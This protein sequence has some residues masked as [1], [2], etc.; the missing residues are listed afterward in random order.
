MANATLLKESGVW[1]AELVQELVQAATHLAEMLNNTLDI[2]KL[3]EG[4]LEFNTGY[5]HI[6]EPVEVVMS[7]QR[8]AA[9]QKQLKLNT[10]YDPSLPR[11][12]QFDKTRVT[13]VVMNLVGNAIKFAPNGGKVDVDVTWLWKCGR[14]GGQCATCPGWKHD[15]N[16]NRDL[17]QNQN[18]NRQPASVTPKDLGSSSVPGSA[19]ALPVDGS[20]MQLSNPSSVPASNRTRSGSTGGA[21]S[22]EFGQKVRTIK[23]A[24]SHLP[25]PTSP[26]AGQTQAVEPIAVAAEPI[27]NCEPTEPWRRKREPASAGAVEREN[28]EY[29]GEEGSERDVEEYG[30]DTV[31]GNQISQRMRDHCLKANFIRVK[32]DRSKSIIQLNRDTQPFGRSRA[33]EEERKSKLLTMVLRRNATQK[34]KNPSVDLSGRPLCKLRTIPLGT[35]SPQ[36]GK[37]D[38]DGSFTKAALRKIIK[39]V[40]SQDNQRIRSLSFRMARDSPLLLESLKRLQR[41]PVKKP[42]ARKRRSSTSTIRHQS[43]AGATKPND[44][45]K[46][47]CEYLMEAPKEGAIVISVT[48]NGCGI[49]EEDQ[50]KLFKPFAQA[51]SN[52]QVRYGGT[53]LG[54]WI[55]QKLA[56]AMNGSIRCRSQL[57]VGSTFTVTIPAKCKSGKEVTNVSRFVIRRR[58]SKGGHRLSRSSRPCV[59]SS[60]L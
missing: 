55:S 24:T 53:G 13:Q 1:N 17:S 26:A 27:P 2:S 47:Y 59:S 20:G 34:W 16:R 5:Q 28:S 32:S 19:I 37:L 31:V 52:V 56:V 43:H 39:R 48:D 33:A 35:T 57:N 60:P 29:R 10:S 23:T 58:S 54:L 45:H 4:K 8:G 50:A 30:P 9:K 38:V 41:P 22:F 18:Q 6:Q 12:I 7:V 11:L 21:M 40:S 14:N 3:E 15:P 44:N 25:L 51:N 46:G 49:S 36:R 42:P